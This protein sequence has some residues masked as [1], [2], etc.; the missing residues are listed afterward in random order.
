MGGFSIIADD[1]RFTHFPFVWCV[2]T[3]Q[4]HGFKSLRGRTNEFVFDIDE[5]ETGMGAVHFCDGFLGIVLAT[6]RRYYF[7]DLQAFANWR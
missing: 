4:S 5:R 2:E 6:K 1:D 3:N 7:R